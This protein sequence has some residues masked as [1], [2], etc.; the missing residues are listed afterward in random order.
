MLTEAEYWGIVLGLWGIG[1]GL[2]AITIAI[3]VPFI[4]ERLRRPHLIIRLSPNLVPNTLTRFLH[5]RVVN[6][7]HTHLRWIDRNPAYD[8]SA[9]LTFRRNGQIICGPVVTKW[10]RAPECI[11]PVLQIVNNQPQRDPPLFNTVEVFDSTKTVFA[12][13]TTLTSDNLRQEFDVVVKNDGD[14]ECYAV[15]G[16]SYRF[17]GLRDPALSIPLGDFTVEIEVIASNSR[18]E[19]TNFRLRNTGHNMG[20]IELT[21]I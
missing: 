16:W 17:Q 13:H 12:H 19:A 9:R 3:A 7:P 5:C 21:E 18:S 10:T 8:T 15:T 20:N 4:V 2:L 11:T 14:N 1:I 6:N